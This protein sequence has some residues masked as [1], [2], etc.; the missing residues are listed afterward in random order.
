MCRRHA[1]TGLL[2]PWVCPEAPVHPDEV[3]DWM[4]SN[5][6]QLNTAKTE[7]LWCS[8]TRQQNQLPPAAVRV[9]EYHV[10]PSTTVR[11]LGI[12]LIDGDVTMR[13]HVSHTVSSCFAV[14]RHLRSIRRSVSDSV[15]HSLVVSL[16]LPR[17]DS[18]NA[19]LACLRHSFVN[20][21]RC[22]MPPSD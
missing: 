6:L 2:S 15:F 3:S 12:I 5:R 21:S 1:D 18:G 20:F 4:M 11:D 9:G 7:I 19:T 13:S 14:L 10:L 22:S 16:D 8:T 17:L